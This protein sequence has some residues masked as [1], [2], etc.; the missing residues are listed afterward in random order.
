MSDIS[1][2]G[3]KELRRVHNE[4]HNIQKPR[5][6]LPSQVFQVVAKSNQRAKGL[7]QGTFCLQTR[8][9]GHLKGTKGT[10]PFPRGLGRILLATGVVA[11]NES[12][13]IYKCTMKLNII[14][15]L[16]W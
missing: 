13:S 11:T 3:P 15:W 12:F 2:I 14:Y 10:L 1:A 16:P 6:A 9:Q 8:L 7:A 4:S 5:E